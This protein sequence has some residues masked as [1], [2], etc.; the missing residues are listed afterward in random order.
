MIIVVDVHFDPDYEGD[1]QKYIF[2][3]RTYDFNTFDGLID[4]YITSE[5][6]HINAKRNQIKKI[7]FDATYFK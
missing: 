5:Y 3:A 1:K 4:Y 2:A 6:D 7:K